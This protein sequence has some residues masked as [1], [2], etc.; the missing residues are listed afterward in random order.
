MQ[1]ALGKHGERL[2]IYPLHSVFVRRVKFGRSSPLN[3]QNSWSVMVTSV[4]LGRLLLTKDELKLNELM[5]R[6]KPV[7]ELVEIPACI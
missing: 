1:S 7:Q 4:V 2:N 6:N 5:D 3:Y